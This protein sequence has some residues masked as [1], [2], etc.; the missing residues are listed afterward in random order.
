MHYLGN[1]SYGSRPNGHVLAYRMEFS[2]DSVRR[3]IFSE[4]NVQLRSMLRAVGAIGSITGHRRLST[5]T[6]SPC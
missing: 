5:D 1:G 3:V 6:P 4:R 2:P